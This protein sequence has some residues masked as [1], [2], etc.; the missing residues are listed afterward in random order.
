MG[1]MD[2]LRSSKALNPHRKHGYL[3]GDYKG[4]FWGQLELA[5]YELRQRKA[6][7]NFTAAQQLWTALVWQARYEILRAA[8]YGGFSNGEPIGSR[9]QRAISQVRDQFSGG[10]SSDG[11]GDV[12]AD[13]YRKAHRTAAAELESNFRA[14]FNKPSLQ[15]R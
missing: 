4:P 6:E 13:L 8:V 11:P 7:I 12:L 2:D 3:D 10:Y 15:Q 14:E 1:L 5:E 9:L